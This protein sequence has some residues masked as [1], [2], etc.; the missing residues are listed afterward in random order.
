MSEL[1]ESIDTLNRRL[2]DEFGVDSSTGRA[3]F[4]IVWA[5]DQLEKRL[6]NETPEGLHLLYPIVREVT[7]YPYF[8]GFYVLERLVIVPIVNQAE[9][10]D[11]KISYEPIWCYR[12][13][14]NEYRPPI[15]TATK[16]V[17]DTLYAA[18]GKKSLAKYKEDAEKLSEEARNE[19][20]SKIQE[21]L[22][23]NETSTGDALA[24][25]EGVVVPQTYTG[26]E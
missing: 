21:E 23:G 14:R 22:Y 2:V 12:S 8:A 16:F 6:M 11:A 17:V 18:L 3:M 9:L 24:Y 7:K 25:R 4:R 26:N 19:R 15:W 10:G 20:I 5:N 1:V 13:E